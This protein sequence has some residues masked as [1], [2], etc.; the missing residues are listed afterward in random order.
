MDSLSSHHES[1]LNNNISVAPN[2]ELAGSCLS[3]QMGDNRSRILENDVEV[4]EEKDAL[5]NQKHAAWTNNHSDVTSWPQKPQLLQR[6]LQ[7]D[8]FSI[9]AV[10]LLPILFLG[11]SLTTL[12]VNRDDR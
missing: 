1:L 9:T 6:S 11:K 3:P 10:S 7:K 12:T 5:S 4:H 2:G 8:L